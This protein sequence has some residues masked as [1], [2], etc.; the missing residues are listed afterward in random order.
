ML[1]ELNEG[2]AEKEEKLKQIDDRIDALG[3]PAN[4]AA[5]NNRIQ[6]DKEGLE[7]ETALQ[8]DRQ[9][10]RQFRKLASRMR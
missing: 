5:W 1:Q 7:L 9:D 4:R 6:D 10:L 3:L 2:I 8:R